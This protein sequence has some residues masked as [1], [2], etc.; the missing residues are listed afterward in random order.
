MSM[1][2]DSIYEYL[3]AEIVQYTLSDKNKK[4]INYQ[5]SGPSQF[6]NNL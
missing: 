1:T 6:F 5:I 2:D 3:H 4:V